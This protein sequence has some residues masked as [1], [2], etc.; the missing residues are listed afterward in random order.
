[1]SDN[2]NRTSGGIGFFG[3]LCVLFIGLKLTNHVDWSWLWV[4]SPLW[5][6]LPLFL[7]VFIIG[8]VI[9]FC[10]MS[11]LEFVKSLLIKRKYKKNVR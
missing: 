1:M 4:L 2:S 10:S 6:P 8:F 11:I 3:L 5:F 9:V 7:G